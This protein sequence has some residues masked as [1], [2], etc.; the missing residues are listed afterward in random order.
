MQ[1]VRLNINAKNSS[2]TAALE[3]DEKEIQSNVI[4]PDGSTFILGGLFQ[5]QHLDTNTGV[6]GLMDIPLIGALFRSK[7]TNM[8]K[9]E[10]IFFITPKLVD[11]KTLTAY[12]VGARDYMYYQKASLEKDRRALQARPNSGR[13]VVEDE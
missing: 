2:F 3:T 7:T 8:T 10:T 9:S 1:M 6:A 4:V 13:W 12:D 11:H 5:D